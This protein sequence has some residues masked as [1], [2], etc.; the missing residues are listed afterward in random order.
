MARIEDV[1]GIGPVY[2][3]RLRAAGCGT[4]AAFLRAVASRSGRHRVAAETGISERL[5]LEWANHVDLMRITGVGPSYARLLEAA[6]VDSVPELAQRN[7]S[8]LLVA[9]DE[10]D[11]VHSVVKQRPSAGQVAEWIGQAQRMDRVITH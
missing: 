5:I 10:T 9:L 2:G 1:E 6:G 3:A 4:S 11:A 8:H 7:P